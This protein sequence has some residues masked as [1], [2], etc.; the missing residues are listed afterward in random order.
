[1]DM[2]KFKD[3]YFASID[4]VF[5][6]GLNKASGVCGG[7]I[8]GQ[9]EVRKVTGVNLVAST[10]PTLADHIEERM[11]RMQ[12]DMDRLKK[13]KKQLSEPNGVLAVSVDDLQFAMYY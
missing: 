4:G 2:N 11:C 6:E 10:I 8:A 12:S 9:K 3:A 13:I 1:M 5:A 7:L